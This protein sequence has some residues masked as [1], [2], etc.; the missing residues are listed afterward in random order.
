VLVYLVC[1]VAAL[2]HFR[3]RRIRGLAWTALAST[4]VFVP[5][6]ARAMVEGA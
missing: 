2:R 1:F 4:T 6:V 3:S 5:F